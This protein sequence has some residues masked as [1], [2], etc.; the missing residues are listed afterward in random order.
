MLGDVGTWS[1]TPVENHDDLYSLRFKGPEGYLEYV[2]SAGACQKQLEEWKDRYVPTLGQTQNKEG[3][4]FDGGKPDLTLLPR[5][6]LWEIAKV[7]MFGETK[8]GRNNWKNG[9]QMTRLLAAAQRHIQQFQ[10]GENKDKETNTLHLAN[11]CA[12]LM[13][14]MWML[15][16]KP[17][18]DNRDI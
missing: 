10:D 9:I 17:D 14:A 18:Y 3:L 15:E 12:N 11:A 7:L 6:P 2:G 16:N 5:G 1:A 4:K 13:F 8:Y